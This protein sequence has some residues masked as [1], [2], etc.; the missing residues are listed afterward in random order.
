M[1]PA[2]RPQVLTALACLGLLVTASSV[3]GC[4]GEKAATAPQPEAKSGG[5]A[6]QKSPAKAAK[7]TPGSKETFAKPTVKPPPAPKGSTLIESLPLYVQNCD[8]ESPCPSLLQPAGET[9]CRKLKLGGHENWRLPDLAEAEK[10]ASVREAL[11][12]AEGFHWTRTAY[13]EDAKQ[14]YIVDPK[15]GQNTTIPRDRKPFTI[16]CVQSP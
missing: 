13:E 7:P 14:A 3:S 9:H 5:E 6:D 11:T 2:F 15:G 16:R 1:L 8:K 10:F 12:N 4:G